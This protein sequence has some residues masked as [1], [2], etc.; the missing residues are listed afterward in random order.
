MMVGTK[1]STYQ[2][3]TTADGVS[4]PI[5]DDLLILAGLFFHG[6]VHFLARF[7]AG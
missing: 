6:V 7:L 4:Q 3:Q 2:N 5:M 1:A